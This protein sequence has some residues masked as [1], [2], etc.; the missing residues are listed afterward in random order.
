[1]GIMGKG[2]IILAKHTSISYCDTPNPSA[3]SLKAS[4]SRSSAA[5]DTVGRSKH[6]AGLE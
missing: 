3:T 1:M 6:Q 2:D 5:N 4:Q